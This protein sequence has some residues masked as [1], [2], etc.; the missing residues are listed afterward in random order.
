M[1]LSANWFSKGCLLLL[2]A[3]LPTAC[4]RESFESPVPAGY[5]SFHCTLES[6]GLDVQ[7]NYYILSDRNSVSGTDGYGTGGLLLVHSRME[8]GRYYAYDL[9]CPYCWKTTANH[10]YA[11]LARISI[12]EEDFYAAVC[13]ACQSKFGLVM[14]GSPVPTAGP[15]NE[16]N[17]ILRQYKAAAYGDQ[18]VVTK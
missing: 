16:E 8:R 14:D 5:V 12:D 13:P 7:G 2:A 6:L 10:S 3:V 1:R 15:A 9:A 17:Y 4:D 11:T 18:L